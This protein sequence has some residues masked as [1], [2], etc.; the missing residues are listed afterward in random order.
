MPS[1]VTRDTSPVEIEKYADE[2]VDLLRKSSL[3]A[4]RNKIVGDMQKRAA[5][6]H[7]MTVLEWEQMWAAKAAPPVPPVTPEP[8]KPKEK[9]PPKP[10]AKKERGVVRPI[11]PDYFH[12]TDENRAHL[13]TWLDLNANGTMM[14]A[15]AIGPAGCGKTSVFGVIAKEVGVP[16]YKVDC[17]A[18]TTPDRWL[19]HKDIQITQDGP[20]TIYVLS[21]F[22]RWVSADGFDPG[23][24]LLDEITRT[25]PVILNILMSL[26][27]GSKS[28]WVPEL[29]IHINVDKGTIFA[30]TAN[31][32][33]GFTGTF[34]L[35]QALSDRFGS[36]LEFT[37]PP[38]ADEI[39]VLTKRTGIEQEDARK[40]VEIARQTRAKAAEGTLQRP[41]STRALLNAGH[42]VATGRSITDAA[43][44]TF[45]KQFSEEGQG[46][47]ERTM[48]RLILQGIAGN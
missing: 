15:L 43:E 14:W 38:A 44:A 27:D 19:G 29:G 45:V 36:T 42:W 2:Y 33:V 41:V 28:V 11:D 3:P 6:I 35:D 30:A 31:I 23:I 10:P 12:I 47:S 4:D 9:D 17:A 16:L 18:V 48:V 13:R 39:N 40:L 34:G 20:Q 26:L 24:V 21:E 37:F 7:S 8:T 46:S 25:P 32:G 5:G 1:Q 22:L